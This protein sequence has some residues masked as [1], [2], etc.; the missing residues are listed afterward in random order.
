MATIWTTR[1]TRLFSGGG[2]VENF[3]EMSSIYPVR[4]VR[5]S[6]RPQPLERGNAIDLPRTFSFDGK[7]IDTHAFL[8][9][10]ETT[11]LVI[12]KDGYLVFENYWLGNDATTQSISWSMA[13]SFTSALMG[14]A[15]GEG[16][17]Q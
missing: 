16:A 1:N 13:K 12:L 10:V 9:D 11:G 3:R 14:I 5:R 7:S 17:I 15:V 4:V 2:Q 6:S 8:K